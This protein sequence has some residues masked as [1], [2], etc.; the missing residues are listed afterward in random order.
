MNEAIKKI[1]ESISDY[2]G[3][4]TV[5]SCIF[6][7]SEAINYDSG[8]NVV[9]AIVDVT[10]ELYTNLFDDEFQVG[11]YHKLNS[12]EYS[13]DASNGYGDARKVGE[14]ASMSLICYG[15]RD[16]VDCY[17]L[18]RTIVDLINGVSYT[19]R[20]RRVGCEVTGSLFNRQQV[21]SA[22]Y[23]G[24]PMFLQPNVFIFRI[25][26]KISTAQRKCN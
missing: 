16:A 26:Y 13:T 6:G 9:P 3:S 23:S 7:L 5:S 8:G 4:R 15:K 22:E 24:L 1:N 20:A 14:T 25:T 2:L 11:I 19:D 18:E 17:D 10:G 21:F 12:K